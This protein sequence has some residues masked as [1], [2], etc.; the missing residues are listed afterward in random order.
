[1]AEVETL[2]SRVIFI[3][4]GRIVQDQATEILRSSSANLVRFRL[5][6]EAEAAISTLTARGLTARRDSSD[7]A[8]ILVDL[9]DGRELLRILCTSA[10]VPDEVI[11][12]RQS[13]ENILL[14]LSG[15]QLE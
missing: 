3:H 14:S 9:G 15:T 11:A 2:A 5:A 10:L 12:Q 1:L 7:E 8:A 6:S 13:V 4:Q